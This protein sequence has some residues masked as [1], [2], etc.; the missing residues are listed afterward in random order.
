MSTRLET[1]TPAIRG[2]TRRRSD[3][4]LL[5]AAVLIC[6]LPAIWG[7]PLY[8]GWATTGLLWAMWTLS[9][10]MVWG[11]AGQ[12]SLA[13]LGLGAV[14]AYTF[15]LMLDNTDIGP[16]GAA[17]SGI[18]LAAVASLAMSVA[19][20]RLRNFYFAILT[21]A[22]ALAITT[23]FAN[24]E[25]AGRT[26]GLLVQRSVLPELSFW[27]PSVGYGDFYALCAVVFV[28][29]YAASLFLTR[30][31]AGRAMQS[32]RDDEKLAS[33]LGHSPLSIKTLAFVL[34]GL[35][36]GAA[37]ILQA[38]YFRLVVP[39]LY[40]T[41]A[42]LLAVML[43]VLAGLGSPAAPLIAG[44]LYTVLYQVLPVSGESRAGILGVIVVL[45]VVLAPGGIASQ[46]R[47]LLTFVRRRRAGAEKE[48]DV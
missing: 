10:N 17:L 25:L 37:G 44:V 48:N 24:W 22:F 40:D 1:R 4:W 16:V 43:L 41:Q 31:F 20:L 8:Y 18:G 5:A 15:V 9:L 36:A 30:S 7:S 42:I 28:V 13:Q 14:S 12:F 26:S 45:V 33:S 38:L 27:R 11:T 29:A 19:A 35:V 6:A 3:R 32:V 46:G 2:V 23:V 47:A 39:E 34:S 21:L